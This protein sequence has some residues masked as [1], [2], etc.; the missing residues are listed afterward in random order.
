VFG[1]DLVVS[2]PTHP[3]YGYPQNP[4]RPTGGSGS[5]SKVEESSDPYIH[6]G[7]T[8]MYYEYDPSTK[9]SPVSQQNPMGSQSTENPWGS[10]EK[11]ANL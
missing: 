6:F 8:D 1:T 2:P 3:G 10:A 9:D 11:L 7:I 4:N 5:L